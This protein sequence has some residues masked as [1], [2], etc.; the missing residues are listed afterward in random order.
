MNRTRESAARRREA[1]T[2]FPALSLP[3]NEKERETRGT[4]W[5]TPPVLP[6]AGPRLGSPRHGRTSYSLNIVIASPASVS[7]PST[8]D[9]EWIHS[10]VDGCDMIVGSPV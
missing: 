8:A 9:S 6:A 4:P 3:Q 5:E 2:S 1:A 10:R 7:P